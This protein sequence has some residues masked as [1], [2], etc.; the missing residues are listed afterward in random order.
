MSMLLSGVSVGRASPVAR[1]PAGASYLLPI[2]G[3]DG[4]RT[5]AATAA[6]TQSTPATSAAGHQSLF[7]QTD[8]AGQSRQG[9]APASTASRRSACFSEEYASMAVTR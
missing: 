2:S 6:A 7:I 3:H 9:A 5:T 8:T 1:P 4:T